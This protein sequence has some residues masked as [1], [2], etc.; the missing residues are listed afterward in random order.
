MQGRDYVESAEI[1]MD[2]N[3]VQPA[4]V[5]AGLAIEIFIKYIILK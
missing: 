4:A 3:R 5:V 1:L 2:Y